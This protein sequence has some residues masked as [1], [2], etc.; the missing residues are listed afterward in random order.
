MVVL[1][2]T[3][4][5]F[6]LFFINYFNSILFWLFDKLKVGEKNQKHRE[7]SIKIKEKYSKKED[8]N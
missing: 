4:S 3:L 1:Y 5:I 2:L 7:G 6:L 8:L